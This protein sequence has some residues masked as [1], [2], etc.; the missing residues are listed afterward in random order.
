[1]VKE[2]IPQSIMP[3]LIAFCEPGEPGGRQLFFV[4]TQIKN[5]NKA[6]FGMCDYINCHFYKLRERFSSTLLLHENLSLKK[7][8]KVSLAL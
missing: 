8:T 7:A 3:W 2:V 6:K 1:M 5:A 4:T